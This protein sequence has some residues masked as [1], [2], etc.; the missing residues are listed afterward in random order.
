M[1][2]TS[3]SQ[4]ICPQ[5]VAAEVCN[6]H[7]ATASVVDPN[8][9]GPALPAGT[10]AIPCSRRNFAQIRIGLRSSINFVDGAR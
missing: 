8:A 2:A 6:L 7:R 1:V 9:C 5:R 10:I 4:T 3:L